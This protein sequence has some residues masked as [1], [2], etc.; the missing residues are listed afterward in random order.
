MDQSA[1]MSPEL[2]AQTSKR[3]LQSG[4]IDIVSATFARRVRRQG[5]ADFVVPVSVL[6]FLGI[7]LLAG[8]L[9]DAIVTAG[10]A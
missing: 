6:V 3:R 5:R 9:T 10:G 7:P 1:R 8:F 2:V 4:L